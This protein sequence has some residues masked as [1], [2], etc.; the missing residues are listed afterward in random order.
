MRG[1]N[2]EVP[3]R[4]RGKDEEAEE[5]ASDMLEAEHKRDMCTMPSSV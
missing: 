2:E 5:E 4:A 3:R 1:D